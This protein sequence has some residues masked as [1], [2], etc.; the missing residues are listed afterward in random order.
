MKKALSSSETSVLARATRRNIPED[1]ILH[2]YFVI[3]FLRIKDVEYNNIILN[4]THKIAASTVW[5]QLPSGENVQKY[6]QYIS[7]TIAV[8]P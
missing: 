1:N 3:F 4:A 7:S 6:L 2:G 8:P 5:L